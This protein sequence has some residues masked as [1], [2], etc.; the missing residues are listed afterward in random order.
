MKPEPKSISFWIDRGCFCQ[1]QC[2]LA[3]TS[4]FKKTGL[5]GTVAKWSK[6]SGQSSEGLWVKNRAE[7]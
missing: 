2:P 6:A 1:G 3:L 4:P 7:I 5:M